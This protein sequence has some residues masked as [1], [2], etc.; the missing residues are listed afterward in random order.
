MP[1]P[2]T[3]Q[4]GATALK[5][6]G[7]AGV[8][9]TNTT[10]HHFLGGPQKSW[11]TGTQDV[12]IAKGNAP[13][14]ATQ[15]PKTT[16]RHR[17]RTSLETALDALTGRART[18]DITPVVDAYRINLLRD[19]CRQNDMFFLVTHWIL[20]VWFRPHHT[21][22]LLH[23]KLNPAHVEGLHI[24]QRILGS[25]RQLSREVLDICVNFP[26]PTSAFLASVSPQ[27]PRGLIESAKSF[28]NC[29]ATNFPEITKIFSLRGWPPCPIELRYALQLPSVVLQKVLYISLLRGRYADQP[30]WVEQATRLFDAALEDPA[31]NAHSASELMATDGQAVAPLAYAFGSQYSRLQNQYALELPQQSRRQSGQL[32][33]TQSQGHPQNLQAP[34][35]QPPVQEH[36]YHRG[37][38]SQPYSS[39]PNH[40]LPGNPS[41]GHSNG[42]DR[43]SA[44]VSQGPPHHRASAN[45][46]HFMPPGSGFLHGSTA[47]RGSPVMN[48]AQRLPSTSVRHAET[49]SVTPQGVSP[50]PQSTP[51]PITQQRGQPSPIQPLIPRD[52]NFVLP[53]L[54]I[55][56]PDRRALHQAHLRN[57]FYEKVGGD[58]AQP[59][60]GKWFQ[61][62]EDLIMLPQLLD[63]K[64]G[65][66][67]WKVQI[68]HSLWTRKAKI[69]EPVGDFLTAR[70][71]ISDKSTQF[72]L[73]CISAHQDTLLLEMT[74]SE[75]CTQPGKWP[76]CL[77]VS[78]NSNAWV[79][80]QRK[81]HH[82]SDLP[83]DVT[84]HLQEGINEVVVCADFT[85]QDAGTVYSMA[86]EVICIANRNTV[87][88][89]MKYISAEES[90]ESIT[91]ALK[92][93]NNGK[94]D[95]ELIIS[96]PVLS[97]DI[98][99]PFMSTMWVTPVRG[100]N[101]QHREC[102][103]LD[104]FLDSRKEVDGATSPDQWKC[105]ICK[106]DAR[107]PMLVMD[108]FLFG[109]R[110]ELARTNKLDAKAILIKEDGTWTARL[111]QSIGKS[112]GRER[113]E[114][115]TPELRA[116]NVLVRAHQTTTSVLQS[117]TST[118]QPDEIIILDDE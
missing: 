113:E 45:W 92:P 98:V 41:V 76:H 89:M 91:A 42:S 83:T 72:R 6:A 9:T 13:S 116:G 52:P 26:S 97:I 16:A 66:V 44:V 40:T 35:Q 4:V 80:F 65:M 30:G 59:S 20:C 57:P 43:P 78:I 96:Q 38:I 108:Q 23:L 115:E 29:L 53:L 109:V 87:L 32:H 67:R 54:A 1:G 17:S 63:P 95:E 118:P 33:A 81:A 14:N 102:F 77:S 55:P 19:A 51:L 61:F 82:G 93:T 84:E 114:T 48:H 28:L 25:S 58:T 18:V 117:S 110:Q 31:Q 69:L 2:G 71:S 8:Q 27:G 112:H 37:S 39:I 105:P 75:F 34:A 107:P 46:T 79:E 86:I 64:S 104:A 68:P 88:S 100:Q 99:D 90:L 12:N 106:K 15:T 50:A 7:F 101:C 85:R 47:P 94:D 49:P 24:L 60:P 111:D 73:K 21:V 56:D 74:L 103:D 22:P 11:M 3:P 36:I 10:T 62:V 70:R 5:N